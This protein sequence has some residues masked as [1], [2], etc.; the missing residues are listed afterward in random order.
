[1]NVSPITTTSTGTSTFSSSE[2]CSSSNTDTS[3]EVSSGQDRFDA[4]NEVELTWMVS[5]IGRAGILATPNTF[6]Y[7]L[8]GWSYGHFEVDQLMWDFGQGK[9]ADYDSDGLTFGGGFEQKLSSKWSIRGE[10]RHTDFGTENFSTRAR[11]TSTD[12]DSEIEQGSD[13]NTSD[14][15]TSSGTSSG[16]GKSKSF[17]DNTTIAKGSIDNDMHVA[18]IGVTRYFTLD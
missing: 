1:L 5:V 4:L 7:G 12:S 2:C 16:S 13:T 18:R 6:L 9:L 17:H 8:A 14:N 10:Y 15:V 3:Y 11:F